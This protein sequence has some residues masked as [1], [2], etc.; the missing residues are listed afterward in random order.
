MSFCLEVCENVMR[1]PHV[2]AC[3]GYLFKKIAMANAK[4]IFLGID[5]KKTPTCLKECS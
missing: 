2:L 4:I 1:L 3:V 5:S